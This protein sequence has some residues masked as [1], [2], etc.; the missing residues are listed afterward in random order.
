MAADELRGPPGAPKLGRLA[1]ATRLQELAVYLRVFT[2]ER[3]RARAYETAARAL[4]ALGP[5]YDQ[6]LADDRL[7]EVPGIGQRIAGTIRELSTTGTTTT[8]ARFNS[9]LPYPLVALS[10]LPG[11]TLPRLRK[12]RDVL[13]IDGAEALETAAREGRLQTIPGFGPKTEQKILASLGARKTPRKQLILREAREIAEQIALH[14]RDI[15]GVT[16]VEVT[17]E[18]RRWCEVVDEVALLAAA[19]DP[20]GVLAAFRTTP[21]VGQLLSDVA[22]D[23]SEVAGKTGNSTT[24]DPTAGNSVGLSTEPSLEGSAGSLRRLRFAILQGGA[25][26]IAVVKPDGFA[27][28]LVRTTGTP[29]H[30]ADLETRAQSRGVTLAALPANSDDEI[31]AAL[32][33][34]AIP[35]ELREEPA[36]VVLAREGRDFSDLITLDDIQGYVHCHTTASDG[37]VDIAGMAEG[38]A[39]RGRH[40]FTVT[41]HS[42]TASYAG[43]LTTDRLQLQAEEIAGF[44]RSGVLPVDVLAGTESDIRADGTLDFPLDVLEGLD[45]V[46]ASVHNRFAMDEAQMTER[47]VTCMRQP[48]FK[49]WGHALGRILLHR[50]PIQCRVPEVLA[51]AA[52]SR[53]TA[54]EINGDPH[55]MDLPLEWLR[56]ARALG[57]PFVISVDAHS[58]RNYDNL[59]Y[60]VHLAR[61][62]GIRRNEV[63]NTR[64]A[65]TFRAAVNPKTATTTAGR[66]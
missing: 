38:A 62:A 7:T 16:R 5:L 20:D 66:P 27:A 36:D 2:K 46:I 22:D 32:G 10:V 25:A 58:L 33:L 61:R 19:A 26:S 48:I 40:Y 15:P 52:E 37:R 1:V 4:E 31:Y 24:D 44:N 51:A 55:R 63:L 59:V 53:R 18:I 45:V 23:T 3:H 60:G 29:A 41:D 8:L 9:E 34:P 42:A 35:P 13:G 47:L 54:I 30:V 43:G 12:L 17:G 56:P 11:L 49:I 14:L 64:D 28:A 57:L 6:L 39:A 65:A 21:L 50:P